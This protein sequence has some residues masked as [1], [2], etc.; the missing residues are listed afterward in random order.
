MINIRFKY[1]YICPWC[2]KGEVL[3][4][5]RGKITLS[6]QCPKCGRFFVADMDSLITNRSVAQKRIG[7]RD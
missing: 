6:I 2:K 3:S 5:S 4:D 1:H 7:R